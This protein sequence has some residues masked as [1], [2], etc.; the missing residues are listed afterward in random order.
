MRGS[1]LYTDKSMHGDL[2]E[3]A[4][5][6]GGSLEFDAFGSSPGS[7][8]RGSVNTPLFVWNEYSE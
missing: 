7:A 2:S 1:I 6:F 8:I 3:A 5:L 4:Y